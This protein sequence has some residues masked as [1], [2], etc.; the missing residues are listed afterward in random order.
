MGLLV[1]VENS[2][3]FANLVCDK[4]RSFD[5]GVYMLRLQATD[6]TMKA[7]NAYLYNLSWQHQSST[8]C[9]NVGK[10]FRDSKHNSDDMCD[11]MDGYNVYAI[12]LNNGVTTYFKRESISSIDILSSLASSIG[13]F[14]TSEVSILAAYAKS[15]YSSVANDVVS[16]Y[17]AS[18]AALK[19]AY[20]AA[21][22]AALRAAGN[23]FLS[24][25]K[26]ALNNL[27]SALTN[28]DSTG[29][30]AITRIRRAIP[31]GQFSSQSAADMKTLAS[32]LGMAAG[33][34][35]P[36]NVV[37]SSWGVP[38]GGG[39]GKL[40]FGV[41]GD[42][43]FVMNVQANSDGKYSCGIL[44]T[45]GGSLGL[46][47]QAETNAEAGAGII[48]QPGTITE[49]QGW[50]VG[51]GV[52]G[53]VAQGFGAGLSWGV[54]QGM[55]GAANAIPGIEINATTNTGV[56]ASFKAGYSK[57]IWQGSC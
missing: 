6:S 51:F 46:S 12:V 56:D 27:Q 2:S 11:Y 1:E 41:E 37:N 48:W 4:V 50:S 10:M 8:A 43:A 25:A 16:G 31:S 36:K 21:I 9:E 32:K 33:K 39:A 26:T 49:N 17:N 20:T 53:G 22:E 44:T 34:N 23:A 29:K 18:V 40:I 38:L 54:S 24:D 15:T 5:P 57:L 45:A 35:I 3:E 13:K 19:A 30:D 55:S 7:I 28:L 42:V 52:S 14:V 47:A